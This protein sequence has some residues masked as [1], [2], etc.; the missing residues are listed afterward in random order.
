M[1]LDLETDS[2]NSIY[3]DLN[4]L[5]RLSKY[6]LLL[7]IYPVSLEVWQE[8]KTDLIFI[9]HFKLIYDYTH[10]DIEQEESNNDYV[11]YEEDGPN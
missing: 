6:Y 8:L 4:F 9:N 10:K 11:D 1:T 2:S 7:G 3:R 5:N